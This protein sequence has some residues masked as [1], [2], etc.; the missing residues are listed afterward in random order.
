MATA[1]PHRDDPA[2]TPARSREGAELATMVGDLQRLEILFA[3]WDA[4]QRGAV[5]AYKRAIDELHAEA[6]RRLI[7]TFKTDPAAL[8]ALRTAVA[9]EVVYAVLRQLELVKP[10]VDERVERAL[11]SIRPML[12]SH[13]GDVELVRVEPPAIEVRFLGA[14]DGCASSAMTFHAGVKQAVFDA[15]PEITEVIQIK[16]A[17]G[18]HAS[19]PASPFALTQLGTWHYALELGE[20]I[21]GGVRA[22]A[23]GG[24][25]LLLARRGGAVTCFDNACAHLGMPLDDGELADGVLTCLHHGFRYDLATGECLTAPTVALASHPAR[26]V[27]ARVEVKLPK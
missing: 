9:D 20:L 14:C 17:G 22:L 6:F 4:N 1:D 19:A 24:R 27:G 10:S 8:A 3:G 7:R 23:I 12:A 21:D 25:A 2:A 11:E 26:V 13:G 15:C 18:G 5:A 16:G